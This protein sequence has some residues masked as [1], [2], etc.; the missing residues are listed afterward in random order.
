MDKLAVL[1]HQNQKLAV[2][3]EEKRR[4]HKLL[5]DRVAQLEGSAEEYAQTLLVVNRSWEQLNDDVQHLLKSAGGSQPDAPLSPVPGVPASADPF[6]R[7]LLAGASAA[8]LKEANDALKSLNSGKTDVE[9]A[10]QR[11][12]DGTKA[13]LASLLAQVHALRAGQ[14][15]STDPTEQQQ[16]QQANLAAGR[17]RLLAEQL[18]QTSDRHLEAIERIKRLENELADAEAV[19]ADSD[20]LSELSNVQRKC[21]ALQSSHGQDLASQ[22]YGNEGPA[23]PLPEA[24]AD[25]VQELRRALQ[26]RTAEIEQEQDAH[27]A[28]KRELAAVLARFG[29]ESSWVPNTEMFKALLQ[30][31]L[32]LQSAVEARGREL[33]ALARERDQADM[34]AADRA[35]VALRESQ[36]AARFAELSAQHK[37]LQSSRA[38]AEQRAMK[39]EGRLAEEKERA[40]GNPTTAELQ[41]MI[42]TLRSGIALKEKELAQAKVLRDRVA[43]QTE[44]MAE[45]KKANQLLLCQVQ[46]LTEFVQLQQLQCEKLLEPHAV[47]EDQLLDEQALTEALSCCSSIASLEHRQLGHPSSQSDADSHWKAKCTALARQLEDHELSKQAAAAATAELAARQQLAAEVQSS[48]ALR[49]E[50]VAAGVRQQALEAQLAAAREE[51]ELYSSE[52]DETSKLHDNMQTQTTRVLAQLANKEEALSS[53]HAEKLKMAQQLSRLEESLASGKAEVDRL[54]AANKAAAA[55]QDLLGAELQRLAGDLA[56][57]YACV[58][59]LHDAFP[60]GSSCSQAKEQARGHNARCGVLE[61]EVRVKEEE[62]ASLQ[63]QLQAA[64]QQLAA[65]REQLAEVEERGVK[66]RS[67]RQRVEEDNKALTAR[68]DKLRKTAS[69]GPGGSAGGRETA[70]EV[71]AMRKLLNCNVCHERQK[72][73][74]ITKCCHVFCDKCIKRNLD[75]RNRKCPGCGTAFGQADVKQFFFT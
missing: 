13:A 58:P 15:S 54:A 14:A 49:A 5:Q 21:V 26:A 30:Q 70:A 73:V 72:N 16:Q 62:A 34:R 42:Q 69:S 4:E 75:S 52:I 8:Q 25:D 48:A 27:F 67:K 35:A 51:C 29:N 1:Q 31:V 12:A 2:Q 55:A 45:C 6:L 32:A 10:L 68:V 66:D 53:A 56:M 17:S 11:R 19:S 40:A 63:A 65:L 47:A 74:I 33:E 7:K 20:Q 71:E 38:E 18:R 41:M 60:A 44:E 9:V 59:R 61:A 22:Q 57:E 46:R 28:T 37:Q 50:L 39:L 3:L 24:A 43:K 36:L 64:Q 23:R